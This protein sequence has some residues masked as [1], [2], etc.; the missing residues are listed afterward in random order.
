MD[1]LLWNNDIEIAFFKESLH[2]FA[3]PEQLF[4]KLK[5]DYYAYIP[6]GFDAEGQTLQSRNSLIGKFTDK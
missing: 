5:G 2:A 1:N 6:R 3:S 4:Y